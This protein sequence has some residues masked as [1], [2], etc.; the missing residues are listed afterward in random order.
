VH[1]YLRIEKSHDIGHKNEKEK[2]NKEYLRRLRL[3]LNTELKAKNKIQTIQAW[4]AQVLRYSFRILIGT[5]KNCEN[6][7]RKQENC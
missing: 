7:I 1:K 4:A 3:V 6:W 5:M 2:L